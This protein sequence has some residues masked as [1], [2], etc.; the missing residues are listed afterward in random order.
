VEDVTIHLL[1]YREAARHLWNTFLRGNA[2]TL[3]D[4]ARL[5]DWESLRDA[6]FSALVLRHVNERLH[7]ISLVKRA[8][9][10]FLR[11]VPTSPGIPAMIS[12]T[13]PAKTYWDNPVQRLD[14]ADDLRFIDFFD[15]DQSGF[16]D[17]AYY[18]VAIIGSVTHPELAGHE[19]LIEVQ[20]ASVF[21]DR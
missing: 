15:F 14:P 2:G 9:I 18:H 16:L 1:R 19:A 10:S 12:R 5:D 17:F 4:S 21:I 20:Y 7:P 13:R 3:P 8:P 6:L 11:V